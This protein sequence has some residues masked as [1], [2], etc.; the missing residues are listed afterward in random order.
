MFDIPEITII[1]IFSK[2]TFGGMVMLQPILY[3]IVPVFLAILCLGFF[4][5]NWQISKVLLS[6]GFVGFTIFAL[7]FL[8]SKIPSSQNW[9]PVQAQRQLAMA[10]DYN[11]K[12]EYVRNRNDRKTFFFSEY[13]KYE[14]MG[15]PGLDNRPLAKIEISE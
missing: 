4:R 15:F 7:F 12:Y 1:N 11:N 9:N 2:S 10:E 6:V 13:K 3:G 8:S 5:I 14:Q